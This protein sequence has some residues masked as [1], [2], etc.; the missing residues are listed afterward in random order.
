MKKIYIALSGFLLFTIAPSFSQDKA[1]DLKFNLPKGSGF[2]YNTNMDVTTKGNAG[3]QDISV[4]NVMTIGYHFSVAG[5]SAGWNKMESTIT[6][7]AMTISSNGMNV[8]YDSDKPL[9]TSDMV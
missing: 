3:G 2:D 8:N 1:I 4:N 6:K 9:D 7:I 5:D